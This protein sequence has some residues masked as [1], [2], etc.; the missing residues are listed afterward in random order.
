[1]KGITPTIFILCYNEE[2]ILPFTIKHYRDRF[3]GCRIVLWDN[4]SD[5]GTHDIALANHCEIKTYCTGGKLSDAKYLELKNGWWKEAET[6][7]VLVCDADEL[8]DINAEQLEEEATEGA[9][10]IK[11]AGFNMISLTD[12]INVPAITHGV[13]SESYDKM[14]LFDRTNIS[15]VNYGPGAHRCSPMGKVR[16]S[17]LTYVT[18]HYKYVNLDFMIAKFARNAARL[19]DENRIKGHGTH[20]LFSPEMIKREWNQVLKEAKPV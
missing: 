12:E 9:T 11:F 18:R 4:E 6:N 16:S 13:R 10:F 5:D 8:C 1:M 20:Y 7:W 17:G 14:Y 3:P 19:S 15:E 2:V